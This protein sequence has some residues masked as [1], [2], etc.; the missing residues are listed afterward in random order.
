MS[1]SNTTF[2]LR[3]KTKGC[4]HCAWDIC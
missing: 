3:S 4:G 1:F 2:P